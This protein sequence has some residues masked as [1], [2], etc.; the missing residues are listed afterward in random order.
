MKLLHLFLTCA[1]FLG[2]APLYG[3]DGWMTNMDKALAHLPAVPEESCFPSKDQETVP[4]P[5]ILEKRLKIS[6]SGHHDSRR[7]FP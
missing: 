4:Q 6:S 5:V 1:V 2:T 3:L 7:G